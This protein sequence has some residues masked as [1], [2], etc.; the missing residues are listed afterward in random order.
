VTF[1]ISQGLS[2]LRNNLKEIWLGSKLTDGVLLSVAFNIVEAFALFGE[3][4]L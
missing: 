2:M 4:R 3:L 1:W